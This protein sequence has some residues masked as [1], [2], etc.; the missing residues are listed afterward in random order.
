MVCR[1]CCPWY[2][3]WYAVDIQKV[4]LLCGFISHLKWLMLGYPS[5]PLWR[6][7]VEALFSG[8][9]VVP[10]VVLK[11]GFLYITG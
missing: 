8:N 6:M 7:R 2:L 3:E 11:R 1:S 10:K 5:A 4:H 9:G